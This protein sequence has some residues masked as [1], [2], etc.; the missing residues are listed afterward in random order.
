MPDDHV[1]LILPP[2]AAQVLAD[3]LCQVGGPVETTRRKYTQAIVQQLFVVGFDWRATNVNGRTY[4]DSDMESTRDRGFVM[5]A[6]AN[7]EMRV[8]K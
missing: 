2:N 3:M 8:L 5:M 1:A 7:I 4:Y 6:N